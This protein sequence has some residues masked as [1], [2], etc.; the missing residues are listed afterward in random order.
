[1]VVPHAHLRLHPLCAVL[2]A[3]QSIPLHANVLSTNG[4]KGAVGADVLGS[5]CAPGGARS[6]GMS[7]NVSI[8]DVRLRV[9]AQVRK[10]RAWGTAYG[11]PP[12]LIEKLLERYHTCGRGA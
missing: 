10:T 9:T 12:E 4:F 8:D 3:V 1:M 11:I 6:V 7:G 2:I 5:K